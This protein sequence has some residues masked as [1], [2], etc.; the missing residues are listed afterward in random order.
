MGFKPF[1][2]CGLETGER[3]VVAHAVKQNN[4]VFVFKSPLNP[5]N[6]GMSSSFYY[7]GIVRLCNKGYAEMGNHLTKHGDGVKD[8][9]F[10]VIDCRGIYKRATERG[11]KGVREPWEEKDEYGTV[12]FAQVQTYGDT[13]HTFVERTN[14]KG[15]D[16]CFLPGYK[17]VEV[18]DALLPTLPPVNLLVI[19]HCVGNQP[20]NEMEDVATWY[21][22]ILA[23]HRFWSVD[24][25]QMHTEYSALRSIVVTDYDEVIKMP[26]N[27]PAAGKRKSQIQEYVDYYGGAGVQHIALRTDNV[28]ASVEAAR[29]RGLEFLTP[30]VTY[31]DDLIQRLKGSKVQIKEDMELIRKNSI[32]VDFDDNGYLLQL[33]TKPCQDRPT[34]FIEFIQRCNH[35]GFGAGNFKALFEAIE[36]DQAARGNL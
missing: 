5:G 4:I 27:E 18:K 23:F 14:Y 13:T 21:T 25:T 28:I 3:N 1:A 16:I 29:A 22:N 33:F 34:L 24:D 15:T 8:V 19:D 2:Y 30:P 31:Y 32:L 12:V 6:E 17:S 10:N 36:K 20:D 9:A 35:S 26:I 11:A 7:F